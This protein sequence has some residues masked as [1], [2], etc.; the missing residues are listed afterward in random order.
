MYEA[1]FAARQAALSAVRPGVRG[2]A[3][4]DAA[5]RV[6][7]SHGFGPAVKHATG[8]GVGFA[9]IDH[10]A[11]PRLSQRSDD[12]LEAGM[13][14]NVEPAIYLDGVGG[15]RHCDMVAVGGT[16]AELLTPFHA[17]LTHLVLDAGAGRASVSV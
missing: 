5:R 7:E 16:G 13:V 1:V 12:V 3:V 9:A 8:H 14:F 15:L 11:R 6:L 17:S 2:S 4:D 10:N